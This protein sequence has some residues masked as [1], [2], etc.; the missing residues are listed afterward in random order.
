MALTSAVAVG[1]ICQ[2][3]TASVSDTE[4]RYRARI[5]ASEL[6][7]SSATVPKLPVTLE[8]V[9]A[10]VVP[11]TILGP[12]LQA[13][14]VP[15]RPEEILRVVDLAR[16]LGLRCEQEPR[17]KVRPHGHDPFA[18]RLVRT[19]RNFQLARPVHAAVEVDLLPGHFLGLIRPRARKRTDSEVRNEP[20]MGNGE[21]ALDLRIGSRITRSRRAS[22][23]F[24]S[25]TGFSLTQ[26][27]TRSRANSNSAWTIRRVF[28]RD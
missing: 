21:D 23:S 2:Y 6:P 11:Q 27:R 25:V 14:G 28:C 13:D 5:T 8:S 12:R 10:V 20:G 18:V 3:R 15:R 4:R 26:R 24:T 9:G 19:G 17:T 16:P 1:K 22:G 7:I